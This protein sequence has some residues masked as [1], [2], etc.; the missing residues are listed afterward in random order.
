[1]GAAKS[2]DSSKSHRLLPSF[3]EAR[4]ARSSWCQVA[5]RLGGEREPLGRKDVLL[6]PHRQLNLAR[7]GL[8]DVRMQL[9]T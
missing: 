4:S 7:K 6:S 2:G 5:G 8:A 3:D 1:M 9:E